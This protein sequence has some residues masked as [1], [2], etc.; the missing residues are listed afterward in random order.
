ML[1]SLYP[2]ATC[3]TRPA[4][5]HML[6]HVPAKADSLHEWSKCWLM[7]HEDLLF[8]IGQWR[9]FHYGKYTQL[10]VTTNLKSLR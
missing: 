6:D 7:F 1:M 4:D 5:S 9:P 10:D 8:I 2:A 3:L